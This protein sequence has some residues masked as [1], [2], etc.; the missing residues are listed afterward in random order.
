MLDAVE[1]HQKSAGKTIPV[2]GICLGFQAMAVH[3]GGSLIN[4]QEVVHGQPRKLKLLRTDHF[5][6]RNIPDNCE[7]GLYHSWAV[8]P[9]T[10]P[11]CFEILATT[12]EGTIMAMAHRTLPFCGLQFHPESIMTLYGKQILMNWLK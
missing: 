6:F 5:L 10:I 1:N 4:L 9:G 2:L 11:S 12:G 8:D 7:V 3:S